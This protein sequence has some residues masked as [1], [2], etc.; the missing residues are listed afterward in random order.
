MVPQ[1][2]Q[3]AVH[4][5]SNSLIVTDRAGNIARIEALLRA[6]TRP[7][8][9]GRGD[10]AAHANATEMSRTLTLLADDKAGQ[11]QRHRAGQG[12]RRRAHQLAAA[13]GRQGR[14]PAAC[15]R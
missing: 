2:S 4:Q 13:L 11:L 9:R 1:S 12:V 7:R 14:A 5:S 6:S 15:A 10:P 8:R 3:L